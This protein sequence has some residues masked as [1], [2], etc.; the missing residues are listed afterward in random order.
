MGFK[1]VNFSYLYLSCVLLAEASSSWLRLMS[2][3]A[4]QSPY[5]GT[6]E[7]DYNAEREKADSDEK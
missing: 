4:S 1:I 6:D 5:F 2:S 3:K 7:D